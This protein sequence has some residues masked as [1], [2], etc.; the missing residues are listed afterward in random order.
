[1][2]AGQNR[3]DGPDNIVRMAVDE[4]RNMG[5]RLRTAS[6]QQQQLIKATQVTWAE[7][8][9]PLARSNNLAGAGSTQDVIESRLDLLEG[10]IKTLQVNSQ[11]NVDRIL[12]GINDIRSILTTAAG[13]QGQQQAQ[14]AQPMQIAPA[15]VQHPWGAPS[16]AQQLTSS[17]RSTGGFVGKTPATLSTLSV[18]ILDPIIGMRDPGLD[19]LNKGITGFF[20]CSG[21]LFHVFTEDQIERYYRQRG[22]ENN[23]QLR[24]CAMCSTAAVAAVGTQYIH[25]GFDRS[26]EESFYDIARHCYE[27]LLETAPLEAMKVCTLLAMY[28]I[29][30][31]ATVALAY[32]EVGL[33]ICRRF[34]IDKIQNMSSS[35][36]QESWLEY[37]RAWRTL[38]FFSGWLASTLG[39]ISGNDALHR[40][41]LLSEVDIGSTSTI[42][43]VVQSEMVKISLLKVKIIRMHTSFGELSILSLSS[44]ME[45]LEA[46]HSMMP[47]VMAIANL[48]V[49][50][51]TPHVRRS[52]YHVHLLYLGSVILLYRRIASHIV[53]VNRDHRMLMLP[54]QHDDLRRFLAEGHHAA[55]HSAIILGM[56]HREQGVFKRCWL[57]IFQAYTTCLVLL[58]S[59]IQS[60]LQNDISAGQQTD[61]EHA[62][63]CLE[64]LGFCGSAD[65]VARKFHE[66]L[67]G[68]YNAVVMS[69]SPPATASTSNAPSSP[70]SFRSQAAVNA[71]PESATASS[72]YGSYSD[73]SKTPFSSA[74]NSSTTT[75]FLAQYFS[76]ADGGDTAVR[77]H[78]LRLLDLLCRPFGD[79]DEIS[80]GVNE[81]L[82][83]HS[84]EDP[85]RYEAA[86]LSE[87]LDWRFETTRPFQ[88]DM[89]KLGI[90]TTLPTWPSEGPRRVAADARPDGDSSMGG[91]GEPA[92]LNASSSLG[93]AA[94]IAVG[95][96]GDS[97]HRGTAERPTTPN[98]FVESSQPNGWQS[99]PAIMQLC[100]DSP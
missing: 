81:N 6:R 9:Q 63:L 88:W 64:V 61:L 33:S 11:T 60:R 99:I 20:S 24:K 48:S 41:I 57:V 50:N 13:S 85:S 68:C 32:V 71:M 35:I 21:K 59:V 45:D 26:T 37:R 39:Y 94:R 72:N 28:N 14:Q 30:N 89:S 84:W 1:M 55:R 49:D 52:I 66:T 15:S 40:N 90:P 86:Q 43:E 56:M 46:W 65:H 92:R 95:A 67:S 12:G 25:D 8:G 80:K 38:M 44:M 16:A 96:G 78:G 69:R 19:A 62:H 91:V 22:P 75:S 31:K 7:S 73:N 77:S 98:R 36:S 97:A 79:P 3:A 93:V 70:T 76:V 34:G 4:L 58:Y 2:A 18:H 29:F 87:R 42:N 100:D 17:L 53:Q 82:S 47:P 54:Q 83:F 27:A 10:L 5:D 51:L 23:V 74:A